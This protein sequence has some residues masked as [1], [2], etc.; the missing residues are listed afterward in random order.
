MLDIGYINE[1]N[2]QFAHSFQHEDSKTGL[3]EYGP[4]GISVP[5]LHKSSINIGYIGTRESIDLAKSWIEKCRHE[6]VIEDLEEN[7]QNEVTIEKELFEVPGIENKLDIVR[8]NRILHRDFIGF[9][10]DS[11][12]SSELVSNERWERILSDKS[13]RDLQTYSNQVAIIKLVDLFLAEIESITTTSPAPDV[14]LILTNEAMEKKTS[15]VKVHSGYF[16]NFRRLLKAKAMSVRNA[17]PIQLMRYQTQLGKKIKGGNPLQ[18]EPTRAWN[19]TTAL[20]YKAGGVPWRPVALMRDTCY[21]GISFYIAVGNE[22]K[23]ELCATMCQAF[24]FLGQGV[25]LRGDVFDWDKKRFGKEPHLKTE[26]A[27]KLVKNALI[28][29]SRLTRTTPQRLVIHKSSE[30]WGD[31]SRGFDE[32]SG[33]RAAAESE[34]KNISIDMIALRQSNLRLIREGI[35]PPARGT[36]FSINEN[37]FLY[38]LGYIPYLRVSPSSFVP[39]P[40]QIVQ[41]LGSSSKKQILTEI[42]TLTKLNVNNS[43]YADGEPITLNFARRVGEILKHIPEDGFVAPSYAFY[44]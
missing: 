43:A 15:P 4:F 18:D 44:I 27:E 35:R 23:S 40:W 9:N 36:Y 34:N 19:F 33:I 11:S 28:E 16:L 20:Y 6:I 12:F 8:A 24:D 13:L 2:L 31:A 41:H 5:G 22:N 21:L 39:R 32:I 25:V 42:L 30:F 38:T 17:V 29:Y 7:P 10:T 26:L 37:Y 1:P 14:I 3:A